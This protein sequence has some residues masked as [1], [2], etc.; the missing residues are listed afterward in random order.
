MAPWRVGARFAATV[1]GDAAFGSIRA[2]LVAADP[3]ARALGRPNREQVTSSRLS[4]ATAIQALELTNGETL[5][6]VLRHGSEKLLDA[7][8][9]GPALIRRV[10]EQGLGRAPTQAEGGLAMQTVGAQPRADGVEDLLWATT[11]LPE[12]QLIH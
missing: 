2:S 4:T 8:Q 9:D 10:F 6:E 1:A 3:L 11:M 7:T 5:A 12:F